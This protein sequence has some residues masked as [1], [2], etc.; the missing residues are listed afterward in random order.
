MQYKYNSRKQTADKR[1]RLGG[2]KYKKVDRTSP[3]LF[4]AFSRLGENRLMTENRDN[5][6]RRSM[7]WRYSPCRARNRF[8]PHYFRNNF[9]FF[10]IISISSSYTWRCNFHFLLHSKLIFWSQLYKYRLIKT[11]YYFCV[12]WN[13]TYLPSEWNI[14]VARDV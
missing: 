8:L 7:C 4:F 9:N 10:N 13:I 2:R 6:S 1:E 12:S 11:N 5:D 3:F 14:D